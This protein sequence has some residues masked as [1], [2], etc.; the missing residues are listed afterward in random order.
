MKIG[1]DYCPNPASK[2]FQ[3]LKSIFGEAKA[4]L[5]W[6]RNHGNPLDMAPNG[7][8]SQLFQTYLDLFN[9][10][11]EK[12]LVAKSKVYLDEF[13]NWFGDWINNPAN[14]SKVVDENG[15]PL[16]VYHGGK[17]NFS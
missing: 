17:S 1:I 11:R 16:V 12:A 9:G 8:Q 4:Y 3:E 5:L 2:E 7:A 14:V 13:L 6:D 15:E 10:D